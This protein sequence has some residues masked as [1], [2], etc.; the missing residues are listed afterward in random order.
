MKNFF[1]AG[2]LT[3]KGPRSSILVRAGRDVLMALKASSLIW[4]QKS[5]RREV[6]FGLRYASVVKAPGAKS[7][8]GISL[9]F[10]Y[11]FQGR[12]RCV[13]QS[14]GCVCCAVEQLRVFR[15]SRGKGDVRDR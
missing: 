1:H 5:N 4:P 6:R 7:N 9:H 12:T 2:G 13:I 3:R 14:K 15:S 8:M 11:S 10:E